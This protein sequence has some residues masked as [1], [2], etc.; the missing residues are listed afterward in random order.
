MEC[1]RSGTVAIA[2]T[3]EATDSSAKTAASNRRILVKPIS[4]LRPGKCLL[5][6]ADFKDLLPLRT[7]VRTRHLEAYLDGSLAHQLVAQRPP[8][9]SAFRKL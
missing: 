7:V 5:F 6:I 2:T 3:V 1:V 4:P 9:A 8:A